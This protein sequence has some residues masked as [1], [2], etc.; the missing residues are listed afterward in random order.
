[1]Y[2]LYRDPTGEKVFQKPSDQLQV[3]GSNGA[4]SQ[5]RGTEGS[6]EDALEQGRSASF[7]R[8]NVGEVK[9]ELRSDAVS[10]RL[11]TV[12]VLEAGACFFFF[13]D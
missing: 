5:S 12:C 10:Q 3:N 7:L 2:A 1:M 6:N 11:F 9:F 4:A 13:A 8:S